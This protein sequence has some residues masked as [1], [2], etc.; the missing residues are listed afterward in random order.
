MVEF[1]RKPKELRGLS[2]TIAREKE[3]GGWESLGVLVA[4][5][6]EKLKA[7][8]QTIHGSHMVVRLA[9]VRGASVTLDI[10]GDPGG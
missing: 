9:D 4:P 2:I 1:V 6:M 10:Q 5:N 3:G 8:M 7:A